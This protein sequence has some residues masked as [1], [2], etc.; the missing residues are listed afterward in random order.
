M[1]LVPYPVTALAISDAQGTDGKNIVAGAVITLTDLDLNV[2]TMFDDAAG[3]NGNTAKTTAANGTKTIYINRGEYILSV[4]GSESKVSISLVFGNVL[5]FTTK[6]E[7]IDST[8]IKIGD[9]INI[10]DR[11]GSVWDVVLASTVIVDAFQF[12][13]STGAPALAL[14]LRVI[15]GVYNV[16]HFG[17]INNGA[18]DATEAIQAALDAADLAGQRA[19]AYF[20]F[21]NYVVS[22]TLSVNCHS[23]M[24]YGSTIMPSLMAA[25]AVVYDIIKR[26]FHDGITVVGDAGVD[27]ANGTIGIRISGTG[28]SASRTQLTRCAAIRC[29]YGYIISTFSVMIDNCITNS[30]TTNIAVYAPSTSQEI[31][32][33]NIIGGNHGDPVGPYAIK[34]GD[35]D[36]STTIP[37]GDN[38]G[39]RLLL[40][41]FACDKGTIKVDS[42]F[43]IKLDSLYFEASSNGKCI[44]LG[45]SGYPGS[46]RQIIIDTCHFRSAKYAVYCDDAVDGIDFRPCNFSGITHCALYVVSDIYSYSYCGGVK[47][48]SFG[49]GQEVHTGQ[50][51]ISAYPFN[52][53]TIDI[54]G[55]LNGESVGQSTQVYKN[56]VEQEIA[57]KKNYLYIG[58]SMSW[59]RNRTVGGGASKTGDVV[60]NIVTMPDQSSVKPFN[61]GDNITVGGVM[62][63]IR[64]VDYEARTLLVNPGVT[65]LPLGTQAITQYELT[66]SLSGVAYSTPTRT[67]G[68]NG[69]MLI[70]GNVGQSGWVY[71]GDAW[72]VY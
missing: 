17:A 30:N 59:A 66:P 71:Q 4:N 44:E 24:E 46:A 57:T 41:G 19:I 23:R 13:Q 25:N 51:A 60:G 29:A 5:N 38:H 9:S 6:Q 55:L 16:V 64:V 36:F 42:V 43:A 28:I 31:N 14:S 32:D 39:S 34:I 26:T 18:T 20:P 45:T 8:F 48:G 68:A 63:I 11:G 22:N 69:S 56:K 27:P 50:R 15:D 12:L 47:T 3:S 62:G 1:N 10:K 65:P 58:T 7:A 61:G 53:K 40:Q 52:A 72:V 49:S 2:I 67:D 70:S 54:Y 21:G 33:L 37:I 35:P